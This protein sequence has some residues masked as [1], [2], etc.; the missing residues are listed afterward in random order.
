MYK[1]LI[2]QKVTHRKVS[3][4]RTYLIPCYNESLC[5]VKFVHNFM[6]NFGNSVVKL[7]IGIEILYVYSLYTRNICINGGWGET[8]LH[9]TKVYLLS[10]SY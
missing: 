6:V 8:F 5:S 10:R 9:L 4:L 7:R 1:Y 3:S 2:L